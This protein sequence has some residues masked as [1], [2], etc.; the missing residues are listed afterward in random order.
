[1]DTMNL[2]QLSPMS[3]DEMAALLFICG[4]QYLFR[5]RA[6]DGGIVHKFVSPAAVRAAFAEETIDTSWLPT[7]LGELRNQPKPHD[8]SHN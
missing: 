7:P 8:P 6:R 4:D 1:M 5:H 2:A 3:A